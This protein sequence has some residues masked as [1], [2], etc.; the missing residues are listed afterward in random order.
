MAYVHGVIGAL[1]AEVANFLRDYYSVI[2]KRSG[3]H[4]KLIICCD[5]S[6]SLASKVRPL[7]THAH[8]R[9]ANRRSAHHSFLCR[10]IFHE[11][12]R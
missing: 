4:R 10:A 7:F 2:L 1:G 5:A 12:A 9:H 3:R 11:G 6:A 8:L